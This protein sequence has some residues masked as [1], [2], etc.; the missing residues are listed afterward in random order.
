MKDLAS[1]SVRRPALVIVFAILLILF[2]LLS[3]YNLGVRELPVTVAPV[4]TVTAEYP[5]ADASVIENQ[6]TEPLESQLTTIEGV[7]VIDSVS[8]EDRATLR[9]EFGRGTVDLDVAANDVRDRVARAQ[10]DLP[11]DAEAPVVRQDDDT[12]RPVL[13]IRVASESGD[14]TELTEVAENRLAD[15]LDTIPGVSTVNI[16]GSR[17]YAMRLW[18]D[19]TLMAAQGIVASDITR[20]LDEQNVELPSGRIDGDEVELTVRAASRL[21]SPADFENLVL[22]QENGEVLRLG[23]VGRAELGSADERGIMRSNGEP[24]VMVVLTPTTEANQIEIVDEALS[25]LDGLRTNLPSHIEAEVVFDGTTYIRNSIQEVIQTILLALLI[26]ILVIFLFLGELRTTVIP[27]LVIPVAIIGAFSVI[28]LSGFSI[29]VLTLLA[30]VLALGLVVDDAIVVLENIYKKI[31]EGIA[32]REAAIEG[33]REVFFAI[34]AT[35]LCL[36]AVFFPILVMGGV[37]GDLFREFG[38]VMAGTIL[39]SS[40]AALTL[41]PM[42]SAKLLKKREELTRFR[43]ITEP[44]QTKVQE[45]Y[46]EEL[47]AFLKL[48]WVIFLLIP[49]AGGGVFLLYNV[50]PDELAP[51]EDRG[52]MR[53]FVE[54]PQGTNFQYVDDFM[55]ETLD[56]INEEV[57]ERNLVMS[58][59]SPS[60]GA[61]QTVN[62]G[63]HFLGLVEQGERQRSQNEIATALG[64]RLGQL[65]RG[66]IFVNQPATIADDFRGLPIQFVLQNLNTDR[67]EEVLPDFLAAAQKRP[68][69]VFA[70]TDLEFNQPELRI[71][72]DRDRAA[73]L[74]VSVR[75]INEALQ[76]GLASLPV[77]QFLI[78]GV[79]Y[80]VIAKA[81]RSARSAPQ[82]LEDYFV[83]SDRGA[84]VP[85][86][87]VT[88][89]EEQGGTPVQYRFN[90]FNAATVSAQLAE[91]YTL[92]D[93]VS[94]MREIAE[95]LLDDSFS[96]ELKGQSR[97]YD[98]TGADLLFAFALA[99]L[100]V[101][102]VLSAQFESFRD[103]LTILVVVPLAI[104]GSL[105]ALWFFELTL[106]I[107]SQI[108]MIL[109]IGL[110]SKNGIL[111]VEFANQLRARGME[112]EEATR[113]AARRRFRPV[114]MTSISTILGILPLALA[115]G[116]GAESR[117]PMGVAFVGGMIVGT[118]FT[119]FVVPAC[120]LYLTRKELTRAQVEAATIGSGEVADP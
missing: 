113:E 83:R 115:V 16:W 40:F 26:V 50:L 97:E 54:T 108:G 35:T 28:L 71:K 94:A 112:L 98:Q 100:L 63:F 102:L 10:G 36:I 89:Q 110:V 119:L 41:V 20:A 56:V 72:V 22:R 62:T 87:E 34:V 116:A 52:E 81:P 30:L 114:I 61:D 93:G 99:I 103:P 3:I 51:Q 46:S 120:Y 23:D 77:D 60:F 57:E 85:L 82:S 74:A 38:A 86:T 104:L 7:E 118:F 2:G 49:L 6:I 31:E 65:P 17:S 106:N 8:R 75:E 32:P 67:I 64:A 24:S 45:F 95:E 55:L 19:P 101:F 59:S 117:V 12:G 9:V 91:G 90:R 4:V 107:F 68:E 27:L 79:Q 15:Q 58:V 78:D 66:E 42:L 73:A 111:I 69:F 96:T 88:H 70:Q 44:I 21:E 18:L 84:L 109:L 43:K 76:L 48:R 39:L 47:N 53:I 11:F 105:V 1:L 5:G 14:L 13:Y 37:T 80:D 29:N 92:G 33:T 25:R